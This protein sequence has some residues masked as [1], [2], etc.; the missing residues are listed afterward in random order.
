MVV[1]K[2][3]TVIVA[4]V[5]SLLALRRLMGERDAARARVRTK[6]AE[7]P[8]NVTRLRQDPRSGIYYPEE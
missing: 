7:R 8:R 2:I 5:L 3:V 6:P 4:G 1:L